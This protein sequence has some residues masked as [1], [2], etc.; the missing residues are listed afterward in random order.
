MQVSDKNCI[1]I[2]SLVTIVD[3]LAQVAEFVEKASL[4]RLFSERNMVANSP[5]PSLT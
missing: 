3:V 4:W 2:T 1:G 5:A